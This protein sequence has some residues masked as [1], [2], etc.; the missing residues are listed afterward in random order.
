MSSLVFSALAAAS[1]LGTALLL[2][3]RRAKAVETMS[4][5]TGVLICDKEKALDGYT[6]ISPMQSTSSCWHRAAMNRASPWLLARP[7]VRAR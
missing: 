2:F 7:S 6:L 1:L 4:T 3:P 5:P